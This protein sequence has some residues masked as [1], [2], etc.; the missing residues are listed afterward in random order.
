MTQPLP[1]LSDYTSGRL[2][3]KELLAGQRVTQEPKAQPKAR[4]Q[5][6][7]RGKMNQT[8]A[9]Y[10]REYLAPQRVAGFVRRW[11]FEPEK[12]RLA[13][14]TYYAPDFRVILDDGTVEFH[15]V[16]GGFTREDAWI[17]L[18]IAAELH[19]YVFRLAVYKKGLWTVTR[20]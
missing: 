5:T 13:D 19:P 18:K 9:R 8:E 2:S 20:V 4:A 16:K 10:A 17:K 15:E 3:P 6:Q 7:L 12:L 11:D 14:A 1:K